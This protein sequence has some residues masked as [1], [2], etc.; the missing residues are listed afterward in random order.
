MGHTLF[1]TVEV[2]RPENELPY[3]KNSKQL[4]KIL[5]RKKMQFLILSKS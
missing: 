2:I 3:F 4:I 1:Y 5:A